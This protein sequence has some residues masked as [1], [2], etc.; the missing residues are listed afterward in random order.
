MATQFSMQ[1]C[2]DWEETRQTN[3]SKK[4]N[5]IIDEMGWWCVVHPPGFHFSSKIGVRWRSRF[6]SIDS[7]P[8]PVGRFVTKGGAKKENQE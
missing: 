7:T 6:E 2:F 8:V 3:A 4:N 1:I 5:T